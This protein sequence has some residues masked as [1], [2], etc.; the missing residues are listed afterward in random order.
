MSLYFQAPSSAGV[1]TLAASAGATTKSFTLSVRPA[2]SKFFGG[3]RGYCAVAGSELRCWE[4]MGHFYSGT[5]IYLGDNAV[6]NLAVPTA[7]SGIDGTQVTYAAMGEAFQCALVG[8]AVKC[9]GDGTAGVLGQ[10]SMDAYFAPTVVSGLSG[11]VTQL[12]VG[13]HHACA[14]DAGTLKCW[15]SNVYGQLGDNTTTQR[16]IPTEVTGVS[17]VTISRLTSLG[18]GNCLLDQSGAMRC[19]GRTNLKQLGDNTVSNRSN[20]TSVIGVTAAIGEVFSNWGISNNC[21]VLTDGSTLQ[22]WGESP[23]N[24]L[25]LGSTLTQ[26]YAVTYPRQV[27]GT[28][29]VAIGDNRICMVSTDAVY[30]GGSDWFGGLGND[31]TYSPPIAAPVQ[32]SGTAG[33]RVEAIQATETGSTCII[34][35]GLPYC[36]GAGAGNSLGINK[37]FDYPFAVRLPGLSNVTALS[38]GASPTGACAI[39]NGAVKCWGANHQGVLGSN[40]VY[41][42]AGVQTSYGLSS[43]ATAVASSAMMTCA[44]VSGAVKC[45]GTD[46]AGVLGIN[47]VKTAAPYLSSD[48]DLNES[49]LANYSLPQ[50]VYGLGANATH[51]SVG[52]LSGFAIVDGGIRAWGVNS[53]SALGDN[54]TTLRVRPVSTLSLTGGVSKVSGSSTASCALKTDGSIYCWGTNTFGH[55]G[56]NT[57]TVRRSPVQ[58]SGFSSGGTD[59]SMSQVRSFACAAVSGAAYCWGENSFGT[60]GDGTTT[61]IARPSA[62]S[63]LLTDVTRVA[64]GAAHAC[65]IKGSAVY[66]WGNNHYGQLGNGTHVQSL[67]PVQVTG[68]PGGATPTEIT[69]GRETTYVLLSNGDV[70]GW[71]LNTGNYSLGQ[72]SSPAIGMTPKLYEAW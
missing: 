4:V 45:W 8:G 18:D 23:F 55:V 37:P 52:L 42:L 34:I 16:S 60:L 48:T 58:V 27:S 31:S 69:A 12:S 20:P 1:L 3:K 28:G 57:V 36:W 46:L 44:V 26:G 68:L 33:V 72:D 41:D 21:V 29:A 32:V 24:Q 11:G 67:V 39:V 13:K 63:G 64:A 10:N 56:D 59:V 14:L 54:T 30:C 71:G 25:G 9:W 70:W 53:T 5:N 22:C 2:I 15:G 65:A 35:A 6:V 61:N 47:Y 62:V 38:N 43:G 17:G 7:V 50:D 51:V 66:C 19:W 49:H 40:S